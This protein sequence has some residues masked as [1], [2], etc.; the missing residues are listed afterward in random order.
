MKILF[1]NV[2]RLTKNNPNKVQGINHTIKEYFRQN[3]DTPFDYIIFCEVMSDFHLSPLNIVVKRVGF[4]KKNKIGVL[5]R[6]INIS[7]TQLGYGILKFDYD[8]YEYKNYQFKEFPNIGI[9]KRK[10]GIIEGPIDIIYY[11]ANSSYNS[12]ALIKAI[13]NQYKRLKPSKR[14]ILLGDMNCNPIELNEK[15]NEDINKNQNRRETFSSIYTNLPTHNKGGTL[16]F[17]ITNYKG[18]KSI[19][20]LDYYIYHP[21]P[22]DHLPIVIEY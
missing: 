2:Y 4:K 8:N 19:Q 3:S 22:S 12:S 14:M 17:A 6:R 21:N 18:I 5:G 11:H 1:W 10:V 9:S 15:L 16:D 13:I 20:V 7:H